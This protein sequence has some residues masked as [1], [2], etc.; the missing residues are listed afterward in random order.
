MEENA[1]VQQKIDLLFFLKLQASSYKKFAW[2]KWKYFKE[3][4]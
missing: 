2:N 4:P 1:E 3:K